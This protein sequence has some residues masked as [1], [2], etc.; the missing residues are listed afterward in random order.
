MTVARSKSLW[1]VLVS[2]VLLAAACA[3]PGA[4]SENEAASGSGGE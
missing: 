4:K 3:P 2:L 1:V